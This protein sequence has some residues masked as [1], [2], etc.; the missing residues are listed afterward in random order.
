MPSCGKVQ[1]DWPQSLLPRITSGKYERMTSRLR[2]TI[3][4]P[5]SRLD[6]G[7]HRSQ[8]PSTALSIAEQIARCNAR[9][10]AVSRRG[11]G[12]AHVEQC[13]MSTAK[14]AVT[15]S[16]RVC[17][18]CVSG[19]LERYCWSTV[20]SCASLSRQSVSGTRPALPFQV[21][22]GNRPIEEA[23]VVVPENTLR[24]GWMRSRAPI[25]RD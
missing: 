10:V 3:E 7:W 23:I 6:C 4:I 11:S 1:F 22:S 8:V 18:S 14:R 12:N 16:L 15:A 25:T 13:K 2:R 17:G 19:P 20:Y 9:I 5:C 24:G 21:A